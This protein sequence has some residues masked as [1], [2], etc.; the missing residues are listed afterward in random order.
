MLNYLESGAR[1][2]SISPA[3]FIY[4]KIPIEHLNHEDLIALYSSSVLP[5]FYSA[6]LLWKESIY[7]SISSEEI[8]RLITESATKEPEVNIRKILT[9]SHATTEDELQNTDSYIQKFPASVDQYVTPQTEEQARELLKTWY[10]T[11]HLYY[12]WNPAIQNAPFIINLTT[13]SPQVV[14]MMPK[15]ITLADEKQGGCRLIRLMDSFYAPDKKGAEWSQNLFDYL[16]PERY[17]EMADLE[18]KK[19]IDTILLANIS[20]NIFDVGCG[21]GLLQQWIMEWEKDNMIILLGIEIS[22]TM[23]EKAKERGE[24][25]ILGNAAQMGSD[26]I[27]KE[28]A[29]TG[30]S[31]NFFNHAV[32]SYVD[33]Y[34]SDIERENIFNT[35]SQLLTKNG[36]FRFNV[37]DTETSKPKW[38]KKY[39]ELLLKAGFSDI[40]FFKHKL[41]ARDGFRIANF[42]YAQK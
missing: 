40:N 10:R 38:R 21:S 5:Y 3:E 17:E 15:Y 25:A 6:F 30:F 14:G 35:V 24:K 13:N 8:N 20:G 41:P 33:N 2:Q 37:Y 27:R 4:K 34:L 7:R 32:M 18:L 42:V 36:S 31:I 11:M 23:L 39:R 28:F 1:S 19:A 16:G 22:N 12:S 9:T 29:K 26:E